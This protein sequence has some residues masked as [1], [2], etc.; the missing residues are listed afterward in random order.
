MIVD[1]KKI[2]E[3]IYAQIK[4]ELD[5]KK[6]HPV[7]CVLTCAP[8]AETKKYLNLKK[9]K[10]SILGIDMMVVDFYKEIPTTEVEEALDTALVGNDGIII[11]LPF[12]PHIDVDVLFKKIPAHLDTDVINYDGKSE[13][14]PPVVGAIKEI[15]DRHGV[16]FAG[17]KV[18]VVGHGRLVGKPAA[19]WATAQRA[20]VTVIDKDTENAE[21][22][23]RSAD[24]I[25]SGAGSPGLITPDKI[26]EGVVIFDAGT[27]EE[28]GML[29][30]DADPSCAGKCSLF[31]PVPGGIGPITI[32][33]LL[34]NLVAM[35]K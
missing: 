21:E 7:L 34:R 2:A 3:E 13:V 12:P 1:G 24:I 29:R 25:I 31:T 5:S 15:A 17:Q 30:G 9:E 16:R 14:L 26:K 18:V 27:T 6:K 33:I 19:L 4:S 28:G 23:L 22:I 8:N 11:Q 32:A 35:S 20:A 10:A